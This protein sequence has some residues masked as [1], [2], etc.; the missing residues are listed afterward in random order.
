MALLKDSAEQVKNAQLLIGGELIAESLEEFCAGAW[1]FKANI[2]EQACGMFVP[3]ECRACAELGVQT[4][5]KNS[6][7]RSGSKR[8]FAT[9]SPMA[10]FAGSQNEF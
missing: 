3:S 7:K 8:S 9:L 5:R 1:E 2:S 4:H 10:V 6:H